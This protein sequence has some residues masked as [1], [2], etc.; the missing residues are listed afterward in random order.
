MLVSQPIALVT[1]PDCD[2]HHTGPGH[3]ESDGRI[4]ALL[5]AVRGDADLATAVAERRGTPVAEEDL[6][7]VHA[8]EHVARVRA[9]SE[10][11]RE[12]GDLVW[13]DP[14]TPVGPDS[15]A[16][17]LAAA[18][19]AVAAAELVAGREAPTAFALPRP[20]GHHA[21]RDQAM[22]FCLFNNVAVAAR[23]LQARG[24]AEKVLVLDWDA[25]HGNGTQDIFYEDPTVFVLSAHIVSGYPS[26]GKASELG[27]GRGEGT[28]RNVPLPR[29][30]GGPRY[31]RS[32]LS[33]LDGALAAFTPD[34]VLISAGF[35]C[36]S[37][38][39]EGGFLLEPEDLHLLTKDVL[40][41]FP[42]PGKVALVLEG[43]YALDRIGGGLVD[44]LRALGGLPPV[45]QAIVR[46]TR[47]KRATGPRS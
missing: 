18:G 11:A 32:V 43:G 40:A 31:R 17:A 1:H 9:A 22:G 19:C 39:P 46:P 16:A 20:P 34:F 44:V 26:T 30:T 23:R 21:N 4:P 6:L 8:P 38:D 3:S 29:G 14:Y 2:L 25:H 42:G 41:R 36:L 47:L 45:V 15:F 37:G 28:N 33:A 24:L 27:A 5:E 10:D 7:R 12:R 35:D 13:L